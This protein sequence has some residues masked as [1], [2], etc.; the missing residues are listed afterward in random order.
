MDAIEVDEIVP[1]PSTINS[2]DEGTHESNDDSIMEDAFDEEPI[3]LFVDLATMDLD[4]NSNACRDLL[5]DENQ[6][7]SKWFLGLSLSL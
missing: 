3:H 7:K 4:M 6:N 5:I 2:K 1:S